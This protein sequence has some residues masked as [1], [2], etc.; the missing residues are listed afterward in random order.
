MKTLKLFHIIGFVTII[1]LF[2]ISIYSFITKDYTYSL[3]C[4]AFLML[5]L[6]TIIKS[7]KK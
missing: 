2:I 1:V 7:L 4:L 5:P 3:V 6:V